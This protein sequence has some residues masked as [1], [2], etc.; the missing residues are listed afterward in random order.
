MLLNENI[1]QKKKDNLID[2]QHHCV[3]AGCRCDKPGRNGHC[4]R[5]HFQTTTSEKCQGEFWLLSYLPFLLFRLE[6]KGGQVVEYT[7]QTWEILT[8]PSVCGFLRKRYISWNKKEV[9]FSETFCHKKWQQQ[10]QKKDYLCILYLWRLHGS[11]FHCDCCL[12]G[13]YSSSGH[14]FIEIAFLLPLP[15]CLCS[16]QSTWAPLVYDS[17][18]VVNEDI[19]ENERNE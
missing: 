8:F 7:S 16:H 6:I 10:Q 3:K 13:L 1:L 5:N 11:R 15:L 14:D 12:Q 4:G 19:Q 9:N 2:V 17:K 18:N